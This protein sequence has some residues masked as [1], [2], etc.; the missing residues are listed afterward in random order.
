METEALSTN[1]LVSLGLRSR[2][3]FSSLSRRVGTAVFGNHQ[4][5][6]LSWLDRPVAFREVTA[7][8]PLAHTGHGNELNWSLC[9]KVQ[10]AQ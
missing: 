10:F 8:L 4:I 5:V 2:S 3:A 6:S 1:R 9:S 7:A